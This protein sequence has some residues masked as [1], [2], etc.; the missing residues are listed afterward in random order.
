MQNPHLQQVL[1]AQKLSYAVFDG[2]LCLVD[3]HVKQTQYFR[4]KELSRFQTTL[5][6]LFPELVGSEDVIR[7][8]LTGKRKSYSIE[9]VNTVDASGKVRYHD[10]LFQPAKNQTSGAYHLF[11]L[12]HDVTNET[13]LEQEVRQQKYKIRLL[14]AQLLCKDPSLSGSLL[15]ESEKVN[16]VRSLIDR[17]AGHKASVLLQGESG[18]GKSLVARL[19]HNAAGNPAAPFVE[20]NCAAIPATLLESELFGY[21]RGAFTNALTSK[22]GLLEEADGGTLFLDEIGELPLSLQV[23]LLT[24]LETRRFRRL[25]STAERTVDM[26]LVTAT[27]KDLKQAMANKEFRQDL[28]FRIN[29]VA[30]VLPPLR[31]L[32]GDIIVLANHFIS[33]LS[34][35]FKKH[36]KGLTKAAEKKLRC[37]PWPGN[38][39]ELRNVLERAMIFADKN[40]VDADDIILTE[41]FDR[42]PEAGNLSRFQIPDGG[43]SLEEVERDLL[44]ASLRK[45]GG[46]QNRAAE[47][48]GLSLDTFRYRI[49]KFDLS[50]T[51]YR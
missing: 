3:H 16:E 24:F 45:A 33:L 49:K 23:K 25:G 22:K 14:Q 37:Y 1:S 41:D 50:P 34:F 26:R 42:P 21:E 27:N 12:I 31:E 15:G 8:I 7:E 46:T 5:W 44:I 28:Y 13:A 30:V 51:D 9:K 17:V 11:C 18:T 39:R 4:G 6:E 32:G 10:L 35:E 38:V 48:L 19:L 43:L 29:V 20:I 47:L 40:Y 2:N 36:M